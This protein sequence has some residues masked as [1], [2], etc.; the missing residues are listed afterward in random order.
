MSHPFVGWWQLS[1]G[2]VVLVLTQ[3]IPSFEKVVEVLRATVASW[4]A[5][6]CPC[7]QTLSRVSHSVQP[8]YLVA[9]RCGQ[10]RCRS[11]ASHVEHAGPR[12]IHAPRERQ[13]HRLIEPRFHGDGCGNTGLGCYNDLEHVSVDLSQV[14][15]VF[16]SK[17]LAVTRTGGPRLQRPL[18]QRT[19]ML[20]VRTE[21]RPVGCHCA[22]VVGDLCRVGIGL[23]P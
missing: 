8:K 14:E 20:S 11:T 17:Q 16:L 13:H 18:A 15:T 7:T 2:I 9:L 19:T 6:C 1:F 21:I 5:L 23:H 10:G 12:I 4:V 3:V 22:H